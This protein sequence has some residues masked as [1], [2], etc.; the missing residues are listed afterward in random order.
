MTDIVYNA[1]ATNT[2]RAILLAK[3]KA[4]GY[5]EDQLKRRTTCELEAINKVIEKAAAAAA[6]QVGEPAATAVTAATAEEDS[7]TVIDLKFSRN[8]SPLTAKYQRFVQLTEM[9][10]NSLRKI[11]ENTKLVQDFRQKLDPEDMLCLEEL[12][13]QDQREFALALGEMNEIYEW[14]KT[15]YAEMDRVYR[16]VTR[17]AMDQTGKVKEHFQRKVENMHSYMVNMQQQLAA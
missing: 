11:S 12:I 15:C 4:A 2:D 5:A 17:R 14:F 9:K 3:A 1:S 13:R 16:E 10:A 8:A 6:G 7:Q